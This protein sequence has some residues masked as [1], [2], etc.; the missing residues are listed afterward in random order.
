MR[1]VIVGF[2]LVAMLLLLVIPTSAQTQTVYYV[3]PG[4]TLS[5]IAA[6]FGTTTTAIARAN[7]I[8]NINRIYVGQRLLIPAPV[9]QPAPPLQGST[10]YVVGRGD[11]LAR[12]AARFGTT[13][14]AIASANGIYNPNLIFAGQ[15]LRIPIR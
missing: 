6:R 15:Q 10:F 14:S 3:R 4:D 1:R 11:T 12:I 5:Q 13:I 2:I 7:G 9:V 8:V